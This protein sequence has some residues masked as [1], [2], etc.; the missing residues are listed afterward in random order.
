MLFDFSVIF[1]NSSRITKTYICGWYFMI[2]V[3]GKEKVHCE[4][5]ENIASIYILLHCSSLKKN[6]CFPS[7]EDVM[8]SGLIWSRFSL[9]FSMQVWF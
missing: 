5:D 1:L 3:Y 6:V 2:L 7:S 8:A 4:E 9:Y